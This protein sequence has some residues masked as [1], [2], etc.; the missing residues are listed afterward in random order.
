L[1][2]Q[3]GV[4]TVSTMDLFTLEIS[5]VKG[6]PSHTQQAS[7]GILQEI[8]K[9]CSTTRRVCRSRNAIQEPTT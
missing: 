4:E 8:L 7:T 5:A 3:T 9:F 2:A 6:Q 1:I